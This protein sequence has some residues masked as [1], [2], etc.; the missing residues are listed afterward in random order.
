[1]KRGEIKKENEKYFICEKNAQVWIET[2][3]YTLIA[4]G[5]IGLVLSFANPKIEGFRDKMVIEKTMNFLMEFDK[6]I[7]EISLAPGN[8]RVT[9]FTISKGEIKIDGEENT[10]TFEI[11]SLYKY[12]EPGEPFFENG[13]EIETQEGGEYK[14]ITISKTYDNYNLIYLGSEQTKV[15]SNAPTPYKISFENKGF[16]EGKIKID[17][18]IN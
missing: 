2:V 16:E 5:L 3:I 18:S 6:N 7:N 1:M 9:E 12:S 13:F 8:K 11:D 4:I 14:K 15:I 10:I 17:I